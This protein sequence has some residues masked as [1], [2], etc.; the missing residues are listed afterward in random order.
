VLKFQ[1]HRPYCQR[2]EASANI[3]F[4][5]NSVFVFNFVNDAY[6]QLLIINFIIVNNINIIIMI[7]VVA[8]AVDSVVI[9]II[10]MAAAPSSLFPRHLI[11]PDYRV[12]AFYPTAASDSC[13]W[14]RHYEEVRKTFAFL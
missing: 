14:R 4:S 11:R 3:G 1:F 12:I 8:A 2:G 5:S 6:N 10:C 13:A 9:D 7:T